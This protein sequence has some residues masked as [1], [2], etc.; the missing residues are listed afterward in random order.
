[1]TLSIFASILLLAT[2]ISMSHISVFLSRGF[3]YSFFSFFLFLLFLVF[4]SFF[5]LGTLENGLNGI[6]ERGSTGSLDLLIAAHKIRRMIG[7]AG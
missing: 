2:S 4:F 7:T 5:W 6:G 1:M 3:S